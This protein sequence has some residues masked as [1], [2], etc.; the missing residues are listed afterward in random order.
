MLCLPLASRAARRPLLA[1][2]SRRRR[3]PLARG[4][5]GRWGLA[6]W[7]RRR[8]GAPL[9]RSWGFQSLAGGDQGL[10]V[11][12]ALGELGENLAADQDDHAVADDEVV[13]LVAGQQEAG[14]GL[15]GDPVELGEQEFFGGHVH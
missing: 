13:E 7:S 8:R 5:S 3:A 12:R 10:A 14:A 9:A 4:G 6:H 1:P 11:E 2:Q 15:G